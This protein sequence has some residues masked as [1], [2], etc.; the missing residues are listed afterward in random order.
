[1]DE[2]KDQAY[3][4]A[5]L[6]PNELSRIWFPL[7]GL[8]KPQVREIA[9]NAN[10]PVADKAESQDLCFLAGIKKTDLLERLR[11]K[12]AKRGQVIATDGTVLAEHE[13]LDR[14]TIG[15]R[16]GVGVANGSPLYVLDKDPD[17]GTVTVGPRDALATTALSVKAVQLYRDAAEVDRIKLRYRSNPVACK[18][19][20][21]VPA[22]QYPRIAVMLNEPFMAAAPGQ[23]ACLLSGD[24]VVGHG[25]IAPKEIAHAA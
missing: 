7:G 12:A 5:R 24:R 10:L 19:A 25:L 17:T 3:M 14:F 4:L 16:R 18:L 22:G 20:E 2:R 23:V 8:E 1:V 13:G 21:S 15:Q 9:R 6:T 11:T